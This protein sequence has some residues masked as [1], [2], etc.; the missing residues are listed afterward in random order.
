MAKLEARLFGGASFRDPDGIELKLGTRKGRALLGFLIVE[1]DRWHSRDRLTGL[2]W[3]DRQ[4]AQARHSLTQELGAI[5]KLTSGTSGDLLQTESERVRLRSEALACDVFVFGEKI[6][7]DPQSAA[8]VYTGTLLDAIGSVDPGFDDWLLGKRA[9]FNKLACEAIGRVARAAQMRGDSSG[10]VDAAKRWLALDP[11]SEAGHR[12]LMSLH[13]AMGNRTEAVRQF[14]QC[15]AI[16]RAELD[17]APSEETLTLFQR[18]KMG[19]EAAGAA[20]VVHKHMPGEVEQAVSRGATASVAG[21]VAVLPFENLSEDAQQAYFADGLSEDLITALSHVRTLQVLSRQSTFAFKGKTIDPVELGE[22]LGVQY[23]VEGSVRRAGDQVRV[24]AKLIDAATGDHIWAERY[25]GKLDGI[26][27]LQDQITATIVGTI[28]HHL[29]RAEGNRLR[30]K[31]PENMAAYD[32][33]LRGMSKMHLLTS[34][35]TKEALACFEKA[36]ELD[37]SYGRAY[38]FASWCYRRQVQQSGLTLSADECS[39]AISLAY[40]GLRLDRNDP[41]VLVYAGATIE[42]LERKLDDALALYERALRMVPTSHRFWNGK[43][44]VHSKMGEPAAALEAGQRAVSLSQDDPAI[45]VAYWAI[46]EAHLQ[47]LRYE[48]AI[49]FA[50]KALHHNEHLAPAQHIIASSAAHLGRTEEA[51]VALAHALESNPDLTLDNFAK[52]FPV[53]RL[54]NLDRY[55]DGLRMAGL[56]AS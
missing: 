53:S 33:M 10:A 13:D 44:S 17:V 16:L 23:L 40:T 22:T 9:W 2:L 48:E 24:S 6:D 50:R 27:D 14:Q 43:A 5:R 39:R 4:Q 26:F 8:S 36:I 46:A 38:V 3:G 32:W 51:K 47:E 41:Y 1:A 31:R 30:G 7:A 54:K 49:D 35:G 42:L 56:R 37:P 29:V 28:E 11:C 12:T 25:D 15:E 19:K 21:R 34:E 52:L 20:S 55:I 45:W 18:V